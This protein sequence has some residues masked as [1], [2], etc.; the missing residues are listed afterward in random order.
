MIRRWAV[1]LGIGAF[2]CLVVAFAVLS[3]Q[4]KRDSSGLDVPIKYVTPEKHRKALPHLGAKSGPQSLALE[5]LSVEELIELLG[6]KDNEVTKRAARK[7]EGMGSSAVPALIKRLSETLSVG[8]GFNKL[9]WWCVNALGS[10]KDKRATDV[11]VKCAVMDGDPHARWRSIWALNVIGEERRA[12]LLKAYLK[13]SNKLERFNAATALSSMDIDDGVK[14]IEEATKSSDMWLRWQAV[15]A[16][17]RIKSPET[18]AVL[19]D[20]LKDPD[21]SIRQEAAMSLGRLK[22]IKAAPAL[23]EALVDTKAG[24][25]WRAARSLGQLGAK[26]AIAALV[27]LLDDPDGSVRGQTAIALGELG[28]KDRSV[29]RKVINML[30]DADKDVRSKAAVAIGTICSSDDVEPVNKALQSEQD[31]RVKRKLERSLRA[32]RSSA[33]RSSLMST[34]DDRP[35]SV[36]SRAA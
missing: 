16:L 28:C 27:K 21:G 10:I 29:A 24:V 3:L 17:G 1:V 15:S 5:S 8:N 6:S 25:R 32:L 36:I 22:N 4:P 23:V 26:E 34:I 12:V 7:L 19:K 14:E 18:L 35:C 30:S 31:E 33:R 9:R 11:L 20:C 2:A 13:S